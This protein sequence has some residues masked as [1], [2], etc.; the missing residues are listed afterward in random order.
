MAPHRLGVCVTPRHVATVQPA[1]SGGSYRHG[2]WGEGQVPQGLQ[3]AVLSAEENGRSVN[4]HFRH[5]VIEAAVPGA[6]HPQQG[7]G[8]GHEG[9]RKISR[10]SGQGLALF[11]ELAQG[12]VSLTGERGSASKREGD[13]AVLLG[14]PR[15]LTPNTRRTSREMG[16]SR[17]RGRGPSGQ[18]RVPVQTAPQAPARVP[19]FR[20]GQ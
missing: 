15:V 5:G 16:L 2:A 18:E 4:G 8:V 19:M 12:L 13:G 9:Q 17:C 11:N 10:V 7:Q 20:S 6:L 3:D 14:Q 1:G